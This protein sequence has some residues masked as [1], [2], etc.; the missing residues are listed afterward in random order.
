MLPI[1]ILIFI[2]LKSLYNYRK[3]AISQFDPSL[4]IPR[5]NFIYWSK[6]IAAMLAWVLLTFAL[7]E[8]RGN[9]HYA[10]EEAGKAIKQSEVK[11]K[12]RKRAHEV[13]I[14]VDASSSMTA[15]DTKGGQSRF[16]EAKDIADQIIRRLEGENASLY[17]F[18]STTT[19]LSPSTINYLFVRLMLRQMKINEGASSGTDLAAALKTMDTDVQAFPS[20]S[21]K[22]VIFLT[23]GGDSGDPTFTSA[24]RFRLF[25][26]G[27]G[28]K[29][30]T[31]LPDISYQ[32]KEVHSSLNDL[33]LKKMAYKGH[34]NYFFANTTSNVE[35]VNRI[36]SEIKKESTPISESELLASVA[37]GSKDKIYDLYFQIPLGLA[38]ILLAYVFLWPVVRR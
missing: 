1:A 5:S 35:I 20:T 22:T 16:S 31:T 23:D 19:Q 6:V 30:G 2:L 26:V 11:G 34:G 13:L 27:L 8:P 18:T 10:D 29:E 25:T 24:Q 7:M 21:A 38:L 4:V 14:F 17:A 28:S 36:V 33:I 12:L 9:E 32:G 3:K 15:K 37:A